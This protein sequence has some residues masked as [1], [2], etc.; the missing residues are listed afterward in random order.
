MGKR[1]LN[2]L[3]IE[4]LQHDHDLLKKEVAYYRRDNEALRNDN[5]QIKETLRALVQ[6]E[7]FWSEQA[8]KSGIVFRL[9]NILNSLDNEQ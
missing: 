4:K 5:M 7:S 6:D 8:V 2:E 1:K 9:K 3:T